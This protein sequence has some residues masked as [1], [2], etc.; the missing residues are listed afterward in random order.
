M[1]RLARSPMPLFQPW[2][3]V[4]LVA[5]LCWCGSAAAAE[6]AVSPPVAPWFQENAAWVSQAVEDV[7]EALVYVGAAGAPQL[8]SHG[9]RGDNIV[10]LTYR[11]PE[12]AEGRALLMMQARYPV[13]L[14]GEPG[15]W[16]QLEARVRGARYDEANNKTANAMILDVV[17]DGERVMHNRIFEQ[18]DA[19]SEYEWE[20][21]EG[22]TTLLV[23]M[24]GFALASFEVR[25]AD[26]EQVQLPAESGGE[27]NLDELI[28][29][30]ALGRESFASVGCI[31]CHA[32]AA[33]D[34]AVKTGPNLWG[35][36]RHYPRDRE[37]ADPEGHR[38]NVTVNES[39][40]HNSV[41]DPHSER[42]IAEKAPAIVPVGEPFLPVMPPYTAEV[43]T[44]Q[45]IDAIGAYLKTLNPPHQQG[46][47]QVWLTE[48]GP[49]NYDPMQDRFLLLV[50]DRVRV[51]RGPMA[52]VS[53]R[54]LH[55]GQP[56][57]L[58]YSFDPRVLG[59]AKL[60]QGGFLNMSGEWRNRGGGGLKPGFESREITLGEGG[61]LIAPLHASGAPVDFSFKEAVF[62]DSEAR[63]ASAYSETDPLARLAEEDAAFLGYSRD[64]REPLASPVFRYRVG[65]NQITFSAALGGDGAATFTL[66]GDWPEAQAFR[67]DA[68]V[69]GDLEVSAGTVADGVWTLPAGVAL[70]VTARARIA[71]MNQPWRPAPSGFNGRVQPLVIEAATAQLP[72]GYT[73]EDYIAP[74]DNYGRD[75]LFE[76]LGVAVAPDGTIVV[77]SRTAG[78]WR[79]VDGEWRQFAEGL[80]DSLGVV[81]EDESGLVVV[82]GHKSGLSR[83]S[84]TNGDGLADR[85]EVLTDAFSYHSNYHS[86][87]HGPVRDPA[88]GDY[89]ITLNLAHNNDGGYFNAGGEYMGTAGGFRGW[90]ARVPAGGGFEPWADGLRSPAGLGFAP[91]GRL[92]YADNQGEYMATSKI[93][94]LRQGGFYGHPAA[95]IDR[96]GQTPES[97]GIAWDAV[98]HTKE[99]PVVLLPQ[100]KLA[101]SPGNPAWDTTGGRFGPFGGDMFIGDQTQSVLM[102]VTT[103]AV[104]GV[105]QGVAIPFARELESG[106]MR[107]VFLPDGSLLLGQTGRGW[108]A[109]G[110]RVSSL[111]RIRWD[112][113]TIAPAIRRM[114]ATS[115]GFEVKLTRPLPA[116]LTPAEVA[117]ALSLVSWTY[118]DAPAYG[119]DELA[120]RTEAVTR[121]VLNPA[122]DALTL[123]L[124]TTLQPQV[125][126]MQ[127][128]RVYHLELDGAALWGEGAATEPGLEAY[129]TLY[130]F[131]PTTADAAASAHFDTRTAGWRDLFAADLGDAEAPRGVWSVSAEGGLS[132]TKDRILWTREEYADFDLDLEFKTAPGANSGVIFHASE[133]GDWVAKSVE[134]QL[135]DDY[136]PEW[137]NHEPTWQCGAL[138]G[139]L[140]AAR[141]AVRP[142]GEW[143]RLSLSVRGSHV[144]AVL[145]EQA[146]IDADLD[147]WTSATTNPDGSAIPPW[148][149]TPYA[150]LPRHGKLGLQ[151]K[152]GDAQVWFR[153]VRVREIH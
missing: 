103:E 6:E 30:V 13:P 61:T 40:L 10:R 85:Y 87:V 101:N 120:T 41:R 58:H 97:P 7:A 46:P 11:L 114:E 64:S 152:H 128:A 57:G 126:E 118:R 17:I 86:Y 147:L 93:F 153:H 88:T 102:R 45:Q 81:V 16:I 137:A 4:A 74:L 78:I 122:R 79:I 100:V 47:V 42:A 34:T 71:V 109:R 66:G 142:P 9:D 119:S 99:L 96:P 20:N 143:N 124:G 69:L 151:G 50:D 82:A 65:R 22:P 53:G 91:D 146:I 1:K 144:R 3:R 25:R 32:L 29:F 116:S 130:R 133:P 121:L 112:G 54:A 141:R 72:D 89:F 77:A 44:D 139:H 117:T 8:R 125:H 12:G 62:R 28:D 135:A 19:E 27:T 140:P 134:L 105:E 145:N 132:A 80:F 33:D 83:I 149:S 129:Y 14:T 150:D 67:L 21:G 84:D 37:I 73:V 60:W 92:W 107:P 136:A 148:M 115:T 138:F 131:A 52:G 104:G 43:V 59:I 68:S 108:Q 5:T 95:L 123:T 110:G 49:Q 39:Y 70:P 38:F 98:K 111:Q 26:F 106:I 24:P 113:T 127:T 35:L 55:V 23:E 15:Q 18:E 56:N 36:F 48:A 94:V 63:L 90:A 76:A 2:M 75:L 31:E 51:Q